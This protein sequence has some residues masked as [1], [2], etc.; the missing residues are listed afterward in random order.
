MPVATRQFAPTPFYP[1]RRLR[2]GHLQTIAGNFMRRTNLLPPAEMRR[3][4]TEDQ[5]EIVCACHWQPDAKRHSAMTL[6]IVHGLEGSID[7]NYVIGTGSKA[8]ARGMNVVRMNMRNCGGTDALTPTL[9]HSGLSADVAAVT[10]TLI[11]D[12]QLESIALLGFSMGGN[13]VLKCA[14][15]W[16]D[17]APPQIK[18]V[19]TVSPAMNLAESAS[20]LHDLP[21]R[22]YELK[23]M[24]GLRQRYAQKRKLFPHLYHDIRLRPFSSIWD[25]DE[26]IT[27]RYSGFTGAADYYER[28]SAARIID[29]IRIP[30]LIIHALDDPFI[31]VTDATRRKVLDNPHITYLETPN[32]GH[33]AFLAE[34]ATGY[35]GRWAEK[36]AVDF[37]EQ[38]V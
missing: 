5:T 13:L 17:N 2:G 25:F 3:F 30:T 29:Q 11:A 36:T 16:A 4:R 33:C 38:F 23:F 14:G 15:E 10:R 34:G 22:L 8:W 19:A 32:G 6:I 12:D 20:A 18:A 27:A 37:I 7:S 31:R 9:Y 26:F 21:N 28:S 1:R 24:R 35:D